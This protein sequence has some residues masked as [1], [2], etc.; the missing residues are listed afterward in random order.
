MFGNFIYFIVAVLVYATYM[1]PD[2]AYFPPDQTLFMFVAFTLAYAAICR[3]R[4]R[5]LIRRQPTDGTAL[6][7]L[8][9]SMALLA[10]VVFALDI[11]ALNLPGLV[12]RAAVFTTIPT[13]EAIVFLCLFAAHLAWMWTCAYPLERLYDHSRKSLR[14]Y[15][16][17]QIRF[18]LP[19]T[20]PWLMISAM[21]DII[22]LLPFDGPRQFLDSLVGQICYFMFFL[23]G[24]AVFGPVLIKRVWNCRRLEPGH[25]RSRI[26]M[27]CRR[28]RMPY[29]DILYWPLFG[30]RMITAGVMGLLGRF[31]FILVTRGLLDWLN[32]EEIDAVIAHEISHIKYRHLMYYLLFFIGYFMLAY[33]L[34]DAMLLA[35]I[36]TAPVDLFSRPNGTPPTALISVAVS[37]LT[38]LLFV[39]YFRFVFG[40]FMRN[41]ERQADLG[42]YSL[43]PNGR[44]L[45]STLQKIAHISGV[46]A[47]KPNWHHFSIRQ[48]IDYIRQCEA[49]PGAIAR[50]HRKINRAMALFVLALIAMATLGYQLHFGPAGK[51]LDNYVL[52][53]V[54]TRQMQSDPD[55]SDLYTALADIHFNRKHYRAAIDAYGRAIAID[56]RNA[57]A[58]NNL[59]WLLATC[60][61]ASYRNPPRALELARQAAQID[62]AVHI[63][64]TL[65]EALFINRHIAEAIAVETRAWQAA[66]PAEKAYF[67]K[68]IERFRAQRQADRPLNIDDAI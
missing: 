8:T 27:L 1:P 39:C 32:T 13:L 33:A 67:R 48:R 5:Q 7:A 30:D 10:L 3:F 31:R 20:L 65:A 52:E 11:Y 2:Q 43:F 35:L 58:L 53:K 64:D 9:R 29:A 37:A 61:D 66:P 36:Y 15:I 57:T 54:I 4:F 23:V 22:Y 47:D 16:G 68:Q 50:H 19:V 28:A 60:A 45:I 51:R 46:S 21:A 12:R 44:A 40:Y 55:N 59:A 42:V 17:S 34:V 49:D 6:E 62:D 56:N 24:I 26:D 41:F 25:V 38:I 18:S 63:L 14:A